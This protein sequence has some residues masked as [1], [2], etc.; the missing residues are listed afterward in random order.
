M[1]RHFATR[2]AFAKS[3]YRAHFYRAKYMLVLVGIL[4]SKPGLRGG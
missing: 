4:L 2:T 3:L 1:K